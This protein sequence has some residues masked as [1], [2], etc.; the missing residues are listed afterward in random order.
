MNKTLTDFED[1]TGLEPGGAARVL[2]VAYVTYSQYRSGMRPMK[3]YHEYHVQAILLLS[4]RVRAQ[5]IKE[6]TNGHISNR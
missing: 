5:L 4:E 2:G 1:Q 6:R 3:T